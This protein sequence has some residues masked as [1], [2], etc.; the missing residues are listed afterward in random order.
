MRWHAASDDRDSAAATSSSGVRASATRKPAPM[1]QRNTC[2]P[3]SGATGSIH[4]LFARACA[5]AHLG[6]VLHLQALTSRLPVNLWEEKVL[7]GPGLLLDGADPVHE[8]RHLHRVARRGAEV[9]AG[10]LHDRD[11]LVDRGVLLRHL[12]IL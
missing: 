4:L 8:L 7:P 10:L 1:P 11:Q 6:R 5:V 3:S 12:E 2:V 9:E